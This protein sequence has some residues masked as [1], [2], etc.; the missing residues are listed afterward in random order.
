[1]RRTLITCDIC[2]SEGASEFSIFTYPFTD[3]AG[4][5]DWHGFAFDLCK[6][7]AISI[8]RNYFQNIGKYKK[9]N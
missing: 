1:M 9:S 7:H 3:S 8:L 2:N 5:T 4:D 6:D